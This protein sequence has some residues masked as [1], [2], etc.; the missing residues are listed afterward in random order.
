MR[1]ARKGMVANPTTTAVISAREAVMAVPVTLPWSRK[2]VERM[3]NAKEKMSPSSAMR[4]RSQ[5][6]ASKVETNFRKL[7][8]TRMLATLPPP[9]EQQS[10]YGQN[11]EDELRVIQF[12]HKPFP[13][14]AEEISQRSDQRHPKDGAEEVEQQELLPRHLQHAGQGSGQD[15]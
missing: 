9:E 7:F 1:R 12:R 11:S 4:N 10:Y 2:L 13:A 8:R 6:S 5:A 14:A 15:A 3:A